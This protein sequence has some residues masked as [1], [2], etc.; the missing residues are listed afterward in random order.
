[1]EHQGRGDLFHRR[2]IVL[3]DPGLAIAEFVG[4]DDCLNII[5]QRVMIVAVGVM[6]RHHEITKFHRV[7]DYGVA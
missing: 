5:L 6:Q 7:S 4:V 3:A 1:M 2:R